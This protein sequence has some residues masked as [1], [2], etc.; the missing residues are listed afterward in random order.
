MSRDSDRSK[1]YEAEWEVRTMLDRPGTLTIHGSV[2]A[3]PE[4]RKF[5]RVEDVQRYVDAVREHIGYKPEIKVRKRKGN[6]KATY[7]YGLNTIAVPDADWSLREIVILH[8]IAHAL[9]GPAGQ[10]HGPRFR[11]NFVALMERVL[12]P[13]AGFLVRVAYGERGLTA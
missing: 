2:I 1:V 6:T 8:E 12:G 5:G 13:E 11:T 7:Q 3:V 9:A 10:S 4:E